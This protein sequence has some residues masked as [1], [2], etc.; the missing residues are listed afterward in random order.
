[1]PIFEFRCPACGHEFER[2]V[3]GADS[4]SGIRCPRCMSPGVE[5][6]L[7][8]FAGGHG[9]SGAGAASAGGGCGPARPGF[10]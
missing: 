1:M 2:L 4:V 8:V 9:S 3:M 7:S 6:L 10:S 5:K